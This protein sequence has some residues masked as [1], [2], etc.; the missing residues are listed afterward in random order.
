MTLFKV[1]PSHSESKLA[2]RLHPGLPGLWAGLR[3][4]PGVAKRRI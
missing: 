2:L 3:L 4:E 1:S